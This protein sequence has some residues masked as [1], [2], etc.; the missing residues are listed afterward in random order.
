MPAVDCDLDHRVDHARGGP[1]TVENH[2]PLCR[3]HHKHGGGRRYAKTGRAAVVWVSPLGC[4]Y[5]T[6]E[7]PTGGGLT[8]GRPPP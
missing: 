2:A 8:G 1:T 6:G 4:T 5:R 7:G 3:H